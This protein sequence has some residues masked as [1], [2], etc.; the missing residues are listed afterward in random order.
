[1]ASFAGRPATTLSTRTSPPRLALSCWTSDRRL[2]AEF[3]CR[4][5]LLCPI[6]QVEK[7][8]GR[9]RRKKLLVGKLRKFRRTACLLIYNACSQRFLMPVVAF[10]YGQPA[11]QTPNSALRSRTH[12]RPPVGQLYQATNCSHKGL[13]ECKI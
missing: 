11:G 12:N 8:P 10:P 4:N 2:G 3:D 9:V 7:P 13:N 6:R 1:M 5:S